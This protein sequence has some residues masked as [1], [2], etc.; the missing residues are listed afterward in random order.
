MNYPEWQDIFNRCLLQNQKFCVSSTQLA[1]WFNLANLED[2]GS[3]IDEK[4]FIWSV[5]PNEEP[6]KGWKHLLDSITLE[7]KVPPELS[8]VMTSIVLDE[9]MLQFRSLLYLILV[10]IRLEL[11]FKKGPSISHRDRIETFLDYQWTSQLMDQI[12]L[13]KNEDTFSSFKM[14]QP[15]LVNVSFIFNCLN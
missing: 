7:Y 13:Y 5:K 1:S 11:F 2:A 15:R 4:L 3:N 14:A 8:T 10:R 12:H 6:I 9:Y